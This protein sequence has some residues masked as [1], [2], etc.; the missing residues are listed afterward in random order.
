MN[1]TDKITTVGTFV[2]VVRHAGE[3]AKAT[4]CKQWSA[5]YIAGLAVGL[6][7]AALNLYQ[8]LS[9]RQPAETRD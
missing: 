8:A 1:T 3:R 9:C 2:A 4:G 5:I 6:G 7:W